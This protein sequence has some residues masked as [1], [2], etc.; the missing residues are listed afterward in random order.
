MRNR[1]VMECLVGMPDFTE[2][3]RRPPV[4]RESLSYEEQVEA[5]Q[6]KLDAEITG[7]GGLSGP[8]LVK[9]FLR[10]WLGCPTLM[11]GFAGAEGDQLR[12]R[13]YP[14]AL[15]RETIA[16]AVLEQ[17]TKES[18]FRRESELQICRH[19]VQIIL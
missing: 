4:D 15:H 6:E 11:S 9:I 18:R 10:D 13:V 12:R 2:V 14:T 3:G 8:Y 19:F 17:L 1:R 7:A 16:V 5:A